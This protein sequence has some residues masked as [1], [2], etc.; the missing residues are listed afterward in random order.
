MDTLVTFLLVLLVIAIVIA[1]WVIATYNTLVR[2]RNDVENGFSGM[3]V[4]LRKRY[5]MIPN[6]VATVQNY[7]THEQETLTRVTAL[8]NQ[9]IKGDLSMGDK[10][11]IDSELSKLMSGIMVAVEDY[12]ELK[13]SEQFM[14]LQR[15]ITE[16]ESQISAARRAFN[17]AVLVYN[18]AIQVF[19]T[20]LVAN[21]FNFKRSNMFENTATER[22][23]PNVSEL[24][25]K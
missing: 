19:P 24:F 5:D 1:L 16:M 21:L 18:N 2:K 4:Q 17:G 15:N 13:A 25:N 10:L 12:P 11:K 8:R 3:D 22:Q 7:A 6:L 14:N 9:A 23:N 20:V